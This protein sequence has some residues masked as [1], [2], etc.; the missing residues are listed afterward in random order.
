M[1]D[2]DG[3]DSRLPGLAQFGEKTLTRFLYGGPTY[4]NVEDPKGGHSS[5]RMGLCLKI[6]L[7]ESN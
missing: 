3:D 4:F 5:S 7:T 2:F 1:N 6:A